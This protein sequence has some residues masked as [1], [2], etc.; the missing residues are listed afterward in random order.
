MGDKLSAAEIERA[1]FAFSIY[2]FEGNETLD[3]FQ[4]DPALR[5]LGLNPT[6]KTVEKLG[7]QKRKGQKKFTIEEFLAILAEAKKDKD[8][9]NKEDFREILRLY[10]KSGDGNMIF[11]ELKHILLSMGEKLEADEVADIIKD[12]AVPADDDGF[13]PYGV[14]L[15]KLMA[16]PVLKEDE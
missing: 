14:F 7:G 8:V 16:G 13:T 9:G 6:L 3:A 1:Q 12:C 5:A 4:L 15:D 10:D 2:D 11:D